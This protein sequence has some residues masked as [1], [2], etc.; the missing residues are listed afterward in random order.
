MIGDVLEHMAQIGLGIDIEPSRLLRR[1]SGLSQAAMAWLVE[2]TRTQLDAYYAH[3]DE[4]LGRRYF[5]H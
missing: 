1:A 5:T 4:L 2:A 3:V